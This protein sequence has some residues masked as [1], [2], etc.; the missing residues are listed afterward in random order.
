MPKVKNNNITTIKLSR[1]TKDRLEKLRSYKRE[2][3][4]ELLEKI[5]N[6]L[7]LTIQDPD[8]SRAKLLGISIYHR[9]LEM[10]QR[11]ILKDNKKYRKDNK[12]F[13]SSSPKSSNLQ[14]SPQSR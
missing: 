13:S 10:K 9:N 5:L 6:L 14:Q 11:R 2:S 7:N 12:S 3:Y 8:K 4:D 1:E